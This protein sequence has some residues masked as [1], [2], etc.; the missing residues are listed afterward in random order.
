MDIYT[1]YLQGLT[2]YMHPVFYEMIIVHAGICYIINVLIIDA[3]MFYLLPDLFTLFTPNNDRTIHPYGY[4]IY[5]NVF[6]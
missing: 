5:L 4:V 6:P 3:I 1:V 2:S